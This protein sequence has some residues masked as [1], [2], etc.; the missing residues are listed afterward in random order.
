MHGDSARS[1]TPGLV[2]TVPHNPRHSCSLGNT[3]LKL[4]KSSG[5]NGSHSEIAV[6]IRKG[7]PSVP[8]Q[9]ITFPLFVHLNVY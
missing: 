2:S 4:G 1:L 3:G 7:V 6:K 8:P 9:L 5:R